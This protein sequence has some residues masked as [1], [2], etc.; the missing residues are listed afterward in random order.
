MKKSYLFC[1]TFNKYSDGKLVVI[2]GVTTNGSPA[3]ASLQSAWVY[4]PATKGWVEQNLSTTASR[5][6][7]TASD[8]TAVV[9]KLLVRLTE[10]KRAMYTDHI[11]SK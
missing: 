4:D 7:S 9:S 8:H 6:P 1:A 5:Y 10:K 3:L 2:G 11:F